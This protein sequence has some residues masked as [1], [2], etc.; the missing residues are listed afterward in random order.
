MRLNE[1]TVAPDRFQATVGA[2]ANK[3]RP[4]N[5][6]KQPPIASTELRAAV[7]TTILN[8][9]L[10]SLLDAVPALAQCSMRR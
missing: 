10:V 3:E 2:D 6:L 8:L 4:W 1:V 9:A 7:A 5:A